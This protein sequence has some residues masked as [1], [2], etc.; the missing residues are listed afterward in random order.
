M[1]YTMRLL[2]IVSS[3]TAQPRPPKS[4]EIIER[5]VVFLFTYL[6]E[7]YIIT[8]HIG[9]IPINIEFTKISSDAQIEMKM[10]ES[11]SDDELLIDIILPI[12]IML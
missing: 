4:T 6:Y 8:L 11:R 1:E 2:I 12:Y 7:Y 3:R 9:T 10:T 5:S